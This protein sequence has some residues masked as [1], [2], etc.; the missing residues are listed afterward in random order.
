M[1]ANEIQ[2]GLAAK[3]RALFLRAT[4]LAAIRKWFSAQDFLE[5]STPVRLPAVAPEAHIDAEPSGGWFLQTSPELCMK[6]LLAAGYGR[7]FQICPCFRAGERGQKH[8]PEFSM[9]EWYR[10]NA[11]YSALER[12]LG[13]LLPFLARELCGASEISFKGEKIELGE[14][15][16]VLTVAEAFAKFTKK[17][18]EEAIR[19]GQFDELMAFE[20]EP[21]LGRGRPTILKDYPA[22][23]AALSRLGVANPS[24]CERLELYVAGVELANGFS[25]LCDSGEQRRRFERENAL[26]L[27]Q[28]KESYPL[29]EPFL[30]ALPDMPPSAGIALGV[31]RLAMLFC[32]SDSIDEVVAFPPEEL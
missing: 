24:I 29:P 25:E 30:K 11:D 28:G 2:K 32:D 21:G 23:L 13:S 27:G 8:L 3:R 19:E 10:A 9:L 31:D 26:R 20:I 7:V 16:E 12:D 17:T 18:P 15:F 5:V 1:D 22:S 6:R 14:G 4:L